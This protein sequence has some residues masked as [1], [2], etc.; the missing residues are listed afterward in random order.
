MNMPLQQIA[1]R[2]SGT[3]QRQAGFVPLVAVG[4]LLGDEGDNMDRTTIVMDKPVYIVKHAQEYILYQIIDRKVKSFDANTFGVL[5]ISLTIP[6]ELQLAEGKSPYTLLN[7][8]YECFRQNYMATVEDGSDTFLNRDADSA[9][10]WEIV[11]RYPLEERRSSY[12]TMSP[13]G[14]T[15]T[16]CLPREKMEDFFRDTQYEQF[17]SFRYIEIGQN[18][19]TS[20]GLDGLE[21]PRPIRYEVFVND[22][23]RHEFLSKPFD[24]YTATE[25]NTSLYSYEPIAFTL[26]ELLKAPEHRFVNGK[27]MVELDFS[28]NRINCRLGK[29]EVLHRCEIKVNGSAEEERDIRQKIED[30]TFRIKIGDRE[31][32]SF[33]KDGNVWLVPATYS[34]RDITGPVDSLLQGKRVSLK[35]WWDPGQR[36]FG[37]LVSIQ[38]VVPASPPVSGRNDKNKLFPD[39]AKMRELEK[40]IL[41]LEDQ[42]EAVKIKRKNDQEDI[43]N[44]RRTIR[45]LGIALIFMFLV[46]AGAG[47]FALKLN[48]QLKKEKTEIKDLG[49]Q[50][51]KLENDNESLRNQLNARANEEAAAA[52]EAERQ[53]A[54]R[55]E[56]EK[57]AEEE[58]RKK[59]AE[60]EKA[61]ADAQK[62]IL[63]MVNEN[64]TI[65]DIRKSEA[66][67]L[68]TRNEQY[69]V[70][71]VKIDVEQ[72]YNNKDYEV[73]PEDPDK[74]I[75]HLKAEV[76][77]VLKKSYSSFTDMEATQLKI[78]TLERNYNYGKKKK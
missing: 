46:T 77:E 53:E 11:N 59:A 42:L 15:G 13:A 45:F 58:A 23:S 54:E 34:N 49:D 63:K 56:A 50:K 48:N 14:L 44:Q 4:V 65:V 27:N 32:T 66:W 52:A 38:P 30:G 76:K 28:R 41:Q 12:V 74:K 29:T 35:P 24:S 37:I 72:K 10:F 75:S 47:I 40:K 55:L 68:L 26:D 70:E 20:P 73:H 39:E 67:K 2:I 17:S 71:A 21:I 25:P 33:D 43:E 60:A 36:R 7:E 6:R 18:C 62:L 61:H 19:P 64:K 51:T 3:K 57:K 78:Q 31:L 16:L 69:T 9:L 8:V 1:L 5:S 22:Q